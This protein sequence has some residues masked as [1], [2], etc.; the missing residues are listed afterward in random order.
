M[1]DLLMPIIPVP[2]MFNVLK[3]H[4]G[5][6]VAFI[7]QF[8]ETQ[9]AE[10]ASILNRNMSNLMT[11]FYVGGLSPERI[12]EEIREDL[13]SRHLY[14]KTDFLKWVKQVNKKFRLADISDGSTWILLNGR[15]DGRYLH[16]HPARDS[17]HAVR[18]RSLA[19]KAAVLTVIAG[20]SPEDSH[21][22][23]H[24]NQLGVEFLGEPPLRGLQD[25]K[26][27]IKIYGLLTQ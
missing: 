22:E 18:I 13:V 8:D 19:F 11:D 4:K 3:H 27:I 14:E 7:R 5:S 12:C 9:L 17:R 24:V 16:I 15:R 26:N 1:P 23:K 6:V 20:C 2:F 10:A 21:F 25:M